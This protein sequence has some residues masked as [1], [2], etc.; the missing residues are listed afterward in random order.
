MAS[1]GDSNCIWPNLRKA[2]L[3]KKA[4]TKKFIGTKLVIKGNKKAGIKS[5]FFILYKFGLI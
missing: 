5:G 3:R 4:V 2:K 1:L